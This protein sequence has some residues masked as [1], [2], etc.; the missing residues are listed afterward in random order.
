[1]TQSKLGQERTTQEKE[2]MKTIFIQLLD[3]ITK[4]DAGPGSTEMLK[5]FCSLIDCN[6][7]EKS[8]LLSMIGKASDKKKTTATGGFM[9]LLKK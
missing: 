7:Q 9:G 4:G 1:M 2:H 6:E 5:I 8:S 3:K